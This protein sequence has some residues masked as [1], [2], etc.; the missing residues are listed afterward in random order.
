MAGCWVVMKPKFIRKTMVRSYQGKKTDKKTL[1]HT[2]DIHNYVYRLMHIPAHL[3]VHTCNIY[4]GKGRRAK[5][6]AGGRE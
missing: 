1:M 3:Y 2:T 4:R 5:G 6:R